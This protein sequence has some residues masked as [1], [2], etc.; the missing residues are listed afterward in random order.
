[1]KTLKMALY[2]ITYGPITC[3]ITY[4]NAINSG[5]V[6]WVINLCECAV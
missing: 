5:N 4:V 1:M 2:K 6:K 3:G